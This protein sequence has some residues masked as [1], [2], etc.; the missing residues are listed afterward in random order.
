MK[1]SLTRL[2]KKLLDMFFGSHP[3]EAVK[4]LR[5]ID[6]GAAGPFLE[7]LD[8]GSAAKSL[9]KASSKTACTALGN[10]KTA[11][12]ARILRQLPFDTQLVFLL[13]LNAENRE[14]MLDSL[15][16]SHA[17]KLR[18]LLH[19]PAG[20]AGYLMDP[21]AVSVLADSQAGHVLEEIRSE[22]DADRYYVYVT[23]TRRCLVGFVTLQT[24]LNAQH[25]DTVA[26]IMNTEFAHLP[27][28]ASEL[29]VIRHPSWR[30]FHEIPVVNRH[31][32]FLGVIRYET[33][34][35]LRAEK[36]S[37]ESGQD[38]FAAAIALS[39]LYWLGMTGFLDTISKPS[40]DQLPESR[41]RGRV[42]CS[43]TASGSFWSA[44][45]WRCIPGK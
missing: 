41:Q 37:G 23:D 21:S 32:V 28:R 39:E 1:E 18:R 12:A 10:M 9:Q 43:L 11:S 19:Y 36:L 2:E 8:P 5:S 3:T 31:G 25:Q 17:G 20:S 42:R 40:S 14:A 4:S 22:T 6:G 13:T 27:A 29:D 38:S 45:T 24:L 26:S 15:P 16:G 34:N 33:L 7:S 44:V 30:D 35:R